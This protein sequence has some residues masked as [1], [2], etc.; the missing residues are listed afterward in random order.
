LTEASASLQPV[1]LEEV[2]KFK[3]TVSESI[4]K[5]C[6]TLKDTFAKLNDITN[7][8]KEFSLLESE[9]RLMVY[10]IIT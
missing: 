3:K 8:Y 4:Y 9:T 7:E 5:E 1:E 2:N 10:N 6:D